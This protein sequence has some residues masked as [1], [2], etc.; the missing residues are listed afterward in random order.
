LI[1]F[2][3]WT[4]DQPPYGPQSLI[5][6]K[7]VTPREDGQYGPLYALASIAEALPQRVLTVTGSRTTG[8]THAVFAATAAAI[9]R[10]NPTGS[11]TDVSKT[12]GYALSVDDGERHESGQYGDDLIL[13]MGPN[14]PI[15]KITIAGGGGS[16]F[17]DLSADAP[18]ARHLAVV[19]EFIMVGNTNDSSQGERPDQVWW[20][21]A[22][23]PSSWPI[24]GTAAA[25]AV[26]SDRQVLADG[27]HIQGILAGIG[28]AAAAIFGEKR[29]WRCDTIGAPLQFGFTPVQ[30][31]RGVY[32]PGSLVSDGQLAFFLSEDGFY[33]FDGT[34]CT[35]IGSG[36][37]D[38]YFLNDL[39]DSQRD[40]IY[41]AV[42]VTAKVVTWAY[43]GQGNIGGLPNKLLMFNRVSGQ[44]TRG[45]ME[46]DCLGPLASVGYTLEG[47]DAL[48]YTLDTLPVSL[49]SRLWVGGGAYIGLVQSSDHRLGQYGSSPLQA[50]FE[51]ADT[52]GP[53]GSRVWIDGMRIYT[54][55]ASVFGAIGWR[56]RISDDPTMTSYVLQDEDFIDQL[57]ACR[58]GRPFGRIPAGTVWTYAQGYD[59]SI[60]Q[61]GRR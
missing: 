8:G 56:D 42:D 32:A 39:D 51:C 52:S 11:W 4:P 6:A 35:P 37:V 54:D 59:F 5:E 27:G 3:K 26:R 17:A 34:T 10:L 44:W 55:A 18:K 20:G 7:N 28:G 57:V 50:D 38:R 60:R 23:D 46:L 9:Y 41:A 2:G 14:T 33:A 25:V 13:T 12:N 61:E 47:L 16:Q 45:E 21:A 36:S 1:P 49:D 40:W 15:Q 53:N 29:I 24:P 19:N 48:P 43:P 30:L 58:Y 31:G 22:G